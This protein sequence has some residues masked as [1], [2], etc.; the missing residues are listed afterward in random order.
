MLSNT[1]IAFAKASPMAAAIISLAEYLALGEVTEVT[2]MVTVIT[3][4]N[5]EEG[6]ERQADFVEGTLKALGLLPKDAQ[7][8]RLTD[9]LSLQEE[10]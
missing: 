5:A 2:E 8:N 10:F 1:H 6:I 7:V 3:S 4:G 9:P